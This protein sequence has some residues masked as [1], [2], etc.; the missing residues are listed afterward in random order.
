[1]VIVTDK[2][3]I[4]DST[5][6]GYGTVDQVVK[7]AADNG[8]LLDV[9]PPPGKPLKIDET[10]GENRVKLFVTENDFVYSNESIE[11]SAVLLAADEIALSPETGVQFIYK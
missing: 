8:L 10:I 11:K 2:Q 6:Q 1:M 5:I 3:S 4:F 7:L 9:I